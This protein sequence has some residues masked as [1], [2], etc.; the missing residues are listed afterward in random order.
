MALFDGAVD[1]GRYLYH[2][3]TR[4]AA[5]GSILPQAQ[6]RLGPLTWT[7]DP[8]E[9]QY[10]LVELG[11][12]AGDDVLELLKAAGRAINGPAKVAC[13]TRDD[14]DAMAEQ[15]D[16]LPLDA[17][18]LSSDAIRERGLRAVVD[19]HVS[20]P[21]MRCSS[22]RTR[23]GRPSGSTA[24]FCAGPTPGRRSARS[25]ARSPASSSARRFRCPTS[26][27]SRSMPTRSEG[28]SWWAVA[29]GATAVRRSCRA[30]TD[31]CPPRNGPT[32]TSTIG[33]RWAGMRERGGA[34]SQAHARSERRR[35]RRPHGANRRCSWKPGPEGSRHAPL[36]SGGVIGGAGTLRRPR[37]AG[38]RAAPV[39]AAG[40]PGC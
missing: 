21:G 25:P 30:R 7:N 23:T 40:P 18:T 34:S 28:P 36:P 3:T 4:A 13:F 10:G 20:R 9:S 31:A 2:Y 27:S 32:T 8:R 19:E 16:Y 37:S 24:R 35:E 5:L 11:T 38:Q 15:P 17:A 6:L 26:P 12:D 39:R 29:S 14:A 33:G 1:P 22:S